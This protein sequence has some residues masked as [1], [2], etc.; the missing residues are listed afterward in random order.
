MVFCLVGFEDF[1]AGWLVVLCVFSNII[2]ILGVSEKSVSKAMKVSVLHHLSGNFSLP[3][4][5]LKHRVTDVSSTQFCIFQGTTYSKTNT[6]W[7]EI[8]LMS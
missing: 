4:S 5:I 6:E 2:Q 7:L 3:S 1:V 8:Y